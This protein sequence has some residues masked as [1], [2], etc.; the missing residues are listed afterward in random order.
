[1]SL[2]PLPCCKL[3]PANLA[4]MISVSSVEIDDVLVLPLSILFKELVLIVAHPFVT[5]N[6]G[7][8]G[9]EVGRHFVSVGVNHVPNAINIAVLEV[10]D[11]ADAAVQIILDELAISISVANPPVPL[12]FFLRVCKLLTDGRAFIF[13]DGSCVS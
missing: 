7:H 3:G 5:S 2:W 8:A 4:V 11:L 13:G 12:E 10:W 9:L 1:M 6:D